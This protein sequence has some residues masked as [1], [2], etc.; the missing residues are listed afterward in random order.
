MHF[1][2]FSLG[3][4]DILKQRPTDNLMS[5]TSKQLYLSHND[6]IFVTIVCTNE[7]N[8]ESVANSDPIV[9]L[10]NPPSIEFVFLDTIPHQYT[11]FLPRDSTQ[12][13]SQNIEFTYGGFKES[14]NIDHYRYMLETA[15]SKTEWISVNKQV[16]YRPF[17]FSII[18]PTKMNK[19]V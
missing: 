17:H 11:Y 10:A 13:F 2:G 5:S 4:D 7:L 3:G 16:Q 1:S 9:I 8:F 18:K 14:E 19:N 12:M 15:E 6:V